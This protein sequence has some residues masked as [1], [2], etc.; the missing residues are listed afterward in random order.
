MPLLA[1]ALVGREDLPIPA[2]L[3]AWGASLVLIISFAVLAVAWRTPR[4]QE[5][6]WRPLSARLSGLPVNPATEV[7]AAAVGVVLLGIAI[8]SG[9]EGT[10]DPSRNFSLTF[11]FVTFWLGL[12]VLSVLFGDLFRAFNPWRAIARV[13]SGGFRLI[14]G[15]TAPA[16]LA[17][18]ERLGQLPAV[19][20]LIAFVWLELI[21][22]A[23]AAIG[24]RPETVA[25]AAV[26][27]TAIT[28]IG[29][30]LFGID[31]WLDRGETFSVYFRMFSTLSVFEVRE[32][33]LGRRRLLSGTVSWGQVPWSLAMV[34]VSIGTTSFDGAQEGALEDPI[35]ESFDLLRDLGLGVVA[36]FRVNGSI[37]LAIV[38][39]AVCLLFVLGIRGMHTVSGSP[40]E[41]E[42]RRAFAGTLIPIALAY[43]VAHYFSLFLFQEQAQFTYLLS[44][45]LGEGS[46]LFGTAGGGIDYG[47]IGANGVWY[48]QVGALI[49]GHVA[50]L[51]LAH[52]RALAIYDDVR[53]ATRSQYW[54]L[55]VMVA[56][57]CLGLYLLSQ[58]N[59]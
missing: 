30:A 38:I 45:P 52:D 25:I 58:A 14:A 44:D 5:E 43:L 8:Y 32:G 48:T 17:Y 21:Y 41:R 12:V 51:T 46:D 15:Q 37:W 33:G 16:P 22:G 18:P 24:L 20:G 6:G 59:A 39:A 50:A 11:V 57:T 9:L 35:R 4:L 13:F 54:M 7:L 40:T 31:Q 19:I 3:F 10:E 2:W 1:H 53:A 27:Y 56:F 55:A 42:L 47:L 36:S 34:L 23:G 28:F 26:V 49:V 29:M